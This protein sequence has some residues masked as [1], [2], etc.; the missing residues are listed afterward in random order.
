[1][2]IDLPGISVGDGVGEGCSSQS[3]LLVGSVEDRVESLEESH[4]ID[5]VESLS[6][7]GANAGNNQVNGTGSTTHGS[8][9][10]T[11]PDLSVGSQIEWNLVNKKL[12]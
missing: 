2:L 5:E 8:I 11:R 7:W 3:D 10:G 12:E 1:M 4:A 6:T 9:K